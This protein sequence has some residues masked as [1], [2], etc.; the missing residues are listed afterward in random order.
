M[1]IRTLN[2]LQDAL[3]QEMAWRVKEIADLKATA[4][5][6]GGHHKS[7]MIRAGTAL[8]YAHWEGFV[9]KASEHYINYLNSQRIPLS[10]MIDP[11]VCAALRA[12]LNSASESQKI[13]QSLVLVDVL[14]NKMDE[15]FSIDPSTVVKTFSNL[16]SSVFSNIARYLDVDTEGYKAR[17]KFID[18]LLL[19]RRNAIAHGE[20]LDITATEWAKIADDVLLLLRHYKTDIENAAQLTKFKKPK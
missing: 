5:S 7:T 15:R 2:E 16:S 19:A 12:S 14:R 18:E 1:K 17:Y 9:K 11:L 20:Y 13:D 3:D 8:I 6:A 10:E 4:K